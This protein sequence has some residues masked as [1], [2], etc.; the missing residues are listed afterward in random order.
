MSIAKEK[1]GDSKGETIATYLSRDIYLW[2]MMWQHPNNFRHRRHFQRSANN[3]YKIYKV[4]IVIHQ[5]IVEGR[6]ETLAEKCDIRLHDS[7]NYNIV[8]LIIRTIFI[9]LPFLPRTRQSI[10]ASFPLETGLGLS[11]RSNASI[12]T[13]YPSGFQ[14]LVYI[15]AFDPIFALNASCSG[16]GSVTLNQLL[17]KYPGMTFEVV[18]VLCEV[19][20]ELVLVL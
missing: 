20:Q 9:A 6:R 5:S 10:G 19:R 18:D 11:Y 12:A 14:F 8:V 4:P 17:G 7:R 1:G 15:F 13:R 2:H 3:K 16:E